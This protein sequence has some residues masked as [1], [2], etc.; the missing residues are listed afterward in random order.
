M[1][2]S[3]CGALTTK[4]FEDSQLPL[5]PLVPQAFLHLEPEPPPPPPQVRLRLCGKSVYFW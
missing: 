1:D 3:D 4:D 5:H 2:V